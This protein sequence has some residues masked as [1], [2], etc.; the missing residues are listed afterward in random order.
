[1]IELVVTIA[2]VG[3][4]VWAIVTYIPMAPAFKR[5][6]IIIAIVCLAIFV[7]RSFGLWSHADIPVPNLRN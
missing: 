1:M 3:L 4:I 2:V 6:I 7:L 5:A